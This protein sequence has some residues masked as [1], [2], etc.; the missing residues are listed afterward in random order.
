MNPHLYLAKE[1]R[2][3]R[4]FTLIELL[5][6]IAI[7]AIL[8]SML[9]PALGKAKDRAYLVND[10]GNLRQILYSATM[11]AGDNDDYLP[12]CG[13]GLPPD[14]DCWAHDAK[15]PDGAGTDSLV[16]ISN[17]VES[18]KRGQLGGYLSD[19]KMLNCPRDV[20]DRSTGK[21]KDDFKR[22]SIKICSYVWNGAT[23]SFAAPPVSIK[24]SKYKLSQ[25]PPTGILVWEGPESED[26]YLYN[27]V[28]NHPHEGISQ[29]HGGN[30]RPLSQKDNVGG[31]APVGNLAGA[32]F[33]VRMDKWFSP[34]MAGKNIWPANPNPAGPNDL[35]YNPASKD[36]TF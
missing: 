33:T 25:L 34:Q 9:L 26:A 5:V 15:I 17:Q 29:R 13:W 1:V 14:R 12:Y 30:R 4:A 10:L 19:V 23:I 24:T 8:A 36:G 11:F 35:W 21:G 22:R 20:A 28:A 7:I 3:F 6:V 2:A 31:I 27:D 18:F 32:S 16:I